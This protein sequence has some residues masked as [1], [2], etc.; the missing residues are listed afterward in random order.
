[1]ADRQSFKPDLTTAGCGV[2]MGAADIVPGVSG[3]TVALVLGIY[4]RLVTAI[5][6]IDS[7]ALKL[8]LKRRWREAAEYT[9]LRFLI[10]LAIGVGS[11]IGGLAF[12]MHYLLEHQLQYTFAVFSGL[13]LGSGIL[14]GRSIPEWNGLTFVSVVIGAVFAWFVVGLQSLQ[15]P[16][17]THWYLFACGMI[18]ICAMI[19]PGISG[20]FILL[21]LG[22]YD[23]VT[24]L[25]RSMLKGD[26]SAETLI[27]VAVFG[28]GCVC[29]LLAFS[30]VLR[31][32]L[33]RYTAVTLATLCGFMLGSL[34]KIWPFKLDLTPEVTKFKLKQFENQWP[35]TFDGETLLT[36]ALAIIAL[37]AVVS[38]EAISRQSQPP[39][40]NAST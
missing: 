38:L 29:G 15:N 10:A 19:L 1:M 18:G 21:I 22:R 13:I 40:D 12:L 26:L 33:G 16:P 28:T 36:F 25:V 6:H 23:E 8:V 37:V 2:L 35:S 32:L 24:G 14:V 3:G 5:S 7:T 30:R 9:D 39:A 4:H 11:G 27:S 17:D 31:W 34:R 20:S